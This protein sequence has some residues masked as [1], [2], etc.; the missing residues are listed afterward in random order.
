MII[1]EMYSIKKLYIGIDGWNEIFT[2]NINNG[3]IIQ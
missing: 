2:P 1:T 3:G